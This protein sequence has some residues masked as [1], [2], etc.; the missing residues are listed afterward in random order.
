MVYLRLLVLLPVYFMLS[1]CAAMVIPVGTTINNAAYNA[2]ERELNNPQESHSKRA[3]KVAIANMNLGIEYM[4]QGE[5]EQAL[6]K[7]NRSILAKPDF[8][9]SYNV[10]GLL[11]QRLGETVEAERRAGGHF[12]GAY[13][14][15]LQRGSFS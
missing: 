15:G 9:P 3:F 14:S 10:L 6:T 11:Y 7:L 4:K 2:A 13:E 5:Y 1:A 12:R 8:A